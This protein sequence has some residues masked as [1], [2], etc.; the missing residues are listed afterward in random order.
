[1]DITPENPYR[2]LD[3]CLRMQSTTDKVI[4]MSRELWFQ[5]YSGGFPYYFIQENAFSRSLKYSSMQNTPRPQLYSQ[6]RETST[7]YLFLIKLRGTWCWLTIVHEISE[8][9]ARLCSSS[10]FAWFWIRMNNFTFSFLHQTCGGS[11]CAGGLLCYKILFDEIPNICRIAINFFW[12][13]GKPTCA[14]TISI[15]CFHLSQV[16][17]N[18]KGLLKPAIRWLLVLCKN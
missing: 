5:W 14:S 11:I 12:L 15:K 7:L 10:R 17:D 18:E 6:T 13:R 2:S 16:S 4:H 9:E 3:S 1:M 8:K